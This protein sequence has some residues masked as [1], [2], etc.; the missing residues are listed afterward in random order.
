MTPR[1]ISPILRHAFEVLAQTSSNIVVVKFTSKYYR[2]NLS[3]AIRI[4]KF[5]GIWKHPKCKCCGQDI[6]DGSV[7][8]FDD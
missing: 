6:D 4:V 8:D 3:E 7:R 5:N 1:T 2:V